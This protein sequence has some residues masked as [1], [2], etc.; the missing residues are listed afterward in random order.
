[1]RES[2]SWTVGLG[3]V[4]G[5]ELRVHASF[6]VCAVIVV[7]LCSMSESE[8]V[9]QL[10]LLGLGILLASVLLHELGHALAAIYLGG[11]VERL[12]IAPF[13][14]IVLPSVPPQPQSEILVAL[15][16]PAVNFLVLLLVAPGLAMS[17][18]DVRDVLLSPLSPKDL[19]DG[20]T[21]LIALRM[22]CWINCLLLLNLFPAFPLDGGHALSAVLRPV[23][24]A[25]AAVMIVGSSAMLCALGLLIMAVLLP[26]DIRPLPSWLPLSLFA[27]FLFF[28]GKNHIENWRPSDPEDT[29]LGYDFSE[30]YTSLD[31]SFEDGRHHQ[32]GVF[33]KWLAERREARRRRME[34]LV[35]AEEARLDEILAR[36]NEV[37][38]QA[39]SPDERL[40]LERASKRYRER[41][42]SS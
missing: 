28:Q 36:L 8:H 22:T 15:A 20:E 31:R 10:S 24:G 26:E 37:G 17:G 3:R 21:W 6:L 39:L 2:T 40:L 32:P 19:F 5:F 7:Y 29:V 30:G 11:R 4:R 23:F 14:D 27:I 16:G 1:M 18:V 38:M 41:L 42:R 25:R 34:D 12:V 13:G 33:S 35:A 9:A